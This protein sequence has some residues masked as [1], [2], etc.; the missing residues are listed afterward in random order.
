MSYPG[1]TTQIRS[2][3]DAGGGGAARLRPAWATPTSPYVTDA[4]V[5][6]EV[7]RRRMD[8]HTRLVPVPVSC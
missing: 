7:H 4:C 8:G 6:Q 5:D 2:L 1:C 3:P